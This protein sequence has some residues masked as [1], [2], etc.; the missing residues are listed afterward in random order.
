[1][2]RGAKRRQASARRERWV[3]G[4]DCCESASADGILG[5][6]RGPLRG[7]PFQRG[8]M[9]GVKRGDYLDAVPTTGNSKRVEYRESR[10]NGCGLFA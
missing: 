10:S 3:A 2:A 7:H 5:E 1:M 8:S 6:K 4:A 9:A